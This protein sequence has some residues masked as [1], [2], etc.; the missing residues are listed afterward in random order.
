MS[1]AVVFD[2]SSVSQSLGRRALEL[3]RDREVSLAE[4]AEHLARLAKGRSFPLEAALADLR[5]GHT[6]STDLDHACI[7]LRR[8]LGEV[9]RLTVSVGS[10]EVETVTDGAHRRARSTT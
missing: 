6:P 9:A 1:A 3:V 7:L 2:A 8:A 10:H 5:R 4:G